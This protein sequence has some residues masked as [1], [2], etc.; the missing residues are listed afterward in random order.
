[1]DQS[2]HFIGIGGIGMSGLAHIL[3]EQGASVTGSDIAPSHV[4]EQL[5]EKG[6]NIFIGHSSNHL[7]SAST[8]VYSTAVSEENP[9]FQGA[10]LQNLP[11]LH[12]SELLHRLMEG[13]SPLLVT[14]TH[15]KTTTSSLLAH[16]LVN[17]GMDPA[18]A[19]G[20]IISNLQTNAGHGKGTYFVAEADESDGSFLQ[21]TPY[22]G[23]IT[24]IDND[25]LD[26]WKTVDALIQGFKQFID[27]VQ[28]YKHLFWCGDDELLR[29]LKPKGFSYGF[30]KKNDLYIE[31]FRQDRWKNIF[32]IKFKEIEYTEIE[33]PLIG[34]HNVLNSAAVF[35]LGI[36]L[37]IPEE[38]IRK[39]FSCFKGVSRR[40]EF[41][42]EKA[43]VAVFDDYG[44]HP[45]EIY[46]T[47]RA[48]KQAIGR[49]RLVVAFQPH[50]YS[51]TRDCLAEF[52]PA[53]APA[54]KLIVTDI[55]SAGEAPLEGVTSSALLEKMKDKALDVAYVPRDQ[56]CSFVAG[57]L[58]PDDVLVTMGAGDI[59]KLGTEVLNLIGHE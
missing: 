55:Y 27:S 53:F 19:V 58:K 44:H 10:R 43:G 11:A 25:H 54:D 18:F 40:A 41:K 26:H 3:L 49:R 24:N 4:T 57:C 20:G 31:N 38:K 9:E 32:D 30:D 2:Y 14:G 12:R 39:A 42:G 33:I 23:I 8:V 51:R 37:G 50:R 22:G 46:A 13:Y 45:T 34:G 5:Q 28:S 56:L 36:Q 15:G 29:S 21:Y 52:G 6:A 35:G 17:A 48:F 16:L 7:K 47:L 1:M 59:T